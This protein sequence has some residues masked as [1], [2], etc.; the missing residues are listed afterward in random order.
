MKNRMAPD[1]PRAIV[2]LAAVTAV[3]L[4][5]A[6]RRPE[7]RRVPGTEPAAVTVTAEES[8]SRPAV[9]TGTQDGAGHDMAGLPGSQGRPAGAVEQMQHIFHE[10]HPDARNALCAVCDGQ[11][12]PA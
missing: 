2:L 7:P 4:R 1:I 3:A 5:A 8:R 11:Y 9:T 10:L 12:G 6:V